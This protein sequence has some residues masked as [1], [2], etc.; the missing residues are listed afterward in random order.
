MTY[1]GQ[2]DSKISDCSEIYRVLQQ[3][4]SLIPKDKPYRG[5][6][7]YKTGDYQ[8]LN[9]FQGEVDSFSGE[10]VIN[11]QGQEIYRAKYCGGLVDQ[12]K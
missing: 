2:V 1:Y 7:E 9:N 4:L 10:E 8:Y 3:A 5:P 11:Y 12:R 6:A